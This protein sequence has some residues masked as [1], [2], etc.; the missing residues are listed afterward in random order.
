MFTDGI[1]YLIKKNQTDIASIT[2]TKC[3][4]NDIVTN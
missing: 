3:S 2:S 1:R 4:N